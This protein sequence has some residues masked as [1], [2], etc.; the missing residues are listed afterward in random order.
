MIH[1][2]D[3]DTLSNVFQKFLLESE[4]L[5]KW[6]K[7]LAG[8]F[9]WFCLKKWPVKLG[10]CSW[11]VIMEKNHPKKRGEGGNITLIQN[12]TREKKNPPVKILSIPPVKSKFQPVKIYQKVPVKTLD[13]PW[14]FS[15]KWAWK[16]ISTR[17]KNRKKSKKGLSR[18]LLIFTE[19]KNTALRGS[20]ISTF[21][22]TC[23]SECCHFVIFLPY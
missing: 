3:L 10:D 6:P 12:S 9:M 20:F 19:K 2:C 14:K 17:E 7:K 21:D 1:F 18:A 8:R 5:Q 22:L 11:K 15:K 4:F 16:W 13:C 23:F